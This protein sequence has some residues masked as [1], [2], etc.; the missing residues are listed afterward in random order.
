MYALCSQEMV[1]S[2]EIVRNGG[3]VI[4]E[5]MFW[6]F[7]KYDISY[8]L[9]LNGPRNICDATWT[10][11][12]DLSFVI[13]PN[14]EQENLYLRTL[15]AFLGGAAHASLG[16]LARKMGAVCAEFLT[17]LV[18]ARRKRPWDTN[19]RLLSEVTHRLLS[20]AHL[21]GLDSNELPVNPIAQGIEKGFLPDYCDILKGKHAE[22]FPP[23]NTETK[24]TAKAEISKRTKASIRTSSRQRQSRPPLRRTGSTTRV[25]SGKVAKSKGP[26]K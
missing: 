22:I 4:T 26:G 24:Q 15:E 14:T 23:N 6:G 2:Q 3:M 9:A 13:A 16:D 11:Y 21:E 12:F 25:A 17:T 5:S 18:A 7:L 20:H 10:S 8:E 19:Y 1:G